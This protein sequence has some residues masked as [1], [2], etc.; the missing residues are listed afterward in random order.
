MIL[1]PAIVIAAFLFVVT[2]IAFAFTVAARPGL[3]HWESVS[4][5]F[6]ALKTI[7][8]HD[9]VPARMLAQLHELRG[10]VNDN[11]RL[12]DQLDLK[13]FFYTRL[14]HPLVIDGEYVNSNEFETVASAVKDELRLLSVKIPVVARLAIV[15]VQACV[16]MLTVIVAMLS[17]AVSSDNYRRSALE[18][19]MQHRPWLLIDVPSITLKLDSTRH[20]NPRDTIPDSL[21]VD[22]VVHNVGRGAATDIIVASIV[23]DTTPRL[24]LSLAES[25]SL[26][27][28]S[29]P[30]AVGGEMP[31]RKAV[32]IVHVGPI[33]SIPTLYLRIKVLCAAAD[34]PDTFYAERLCYLETKRLLA[35]LA[36]GETIR[37]KRASYEAYAFRR[38]VG[39]AVARF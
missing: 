9:D 14:Q 26:R 6:E 3:E 25:E 7:V 16:G 17:F 27:Q 4:R 5:K 33:D 22:Y 29:Y 8:L 38:L 11:P 24:L 21:L 35:E 12:L 30:L 39:R 28:P 20:R 19:R 15:P 18:Y 10:L 32:P 23:V 36:P 2:V 1:G 13:Q 37:T 31:Y 34:V